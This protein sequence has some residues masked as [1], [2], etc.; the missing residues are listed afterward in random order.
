MDDEAVMAHEMAAQQANA[1]LSVVQAS[2]AVRSRSALD[3]WL[4]GEIQDF[5][6][7]DVV[8][9]AWGDFQQGAISWDFVPCGSDCKGLPLNDSDVRGLLVGLFD[10]WTANRQLPVAM[11]ASD[12]R[13]DNK[14]LF[15]PTAR[16]RV[17]L[18][19]GLKDCRG[20]YD[21]LYVFVGPASLQHERAK[22]LLRLLL[23][24]IDSGFRQAVAPAARPVPAPASTF[25]AAPEPYH[26]SRAG[27]PQQPLSAREREVMHWVRAGK[28]NSEIASIMNLSTF[29]VKNHM[30]RIYKKMDVLNRAQAVGQLGAHA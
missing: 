8:M 9:V 6:P 21:C 27:E 13:I 30:R 28:T 12:L 16:S 22:D 15:P 2:C 20:E 17:A 14:P 26:E 10:R 5:I 1:L 25:S 24:S 23:P 29:T 19:H 11:P 18:A 7:H 3:A 4:Q